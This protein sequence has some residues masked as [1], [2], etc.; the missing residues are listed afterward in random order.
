MTIDYGQLIG[1]EARAET[2]V[3]AARAAASARIAARL[4]AAEAAAFDGASTAERLSWAT[5]EA[6]ARAIAEGMA[7]ADQRALIEAEAQLTE[8][9]VEALANRILARAQDHQRTIA[10]L[11]GLRRK[12]QAMLVRAKDLN[13]LTEVMDRIDAALSQHLVPEVQKAGAVEI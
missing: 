13:Q 9:A 1:A 3:Q 4:D 8:E 2:I 11:T 5:K 7:R 10:V 6:A 12:A